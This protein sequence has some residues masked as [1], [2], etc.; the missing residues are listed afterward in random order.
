MRVETPAA[1][2]LARPHPALGP[3]DFLPHKSVWF[4]QEPGPAAQSVLQ[5]MAGPPATVRLLDLQG[6][7]RRTLS[8]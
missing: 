1:A 7:R 4:T 3:Q 8:R 5:F 2:A 6:Y